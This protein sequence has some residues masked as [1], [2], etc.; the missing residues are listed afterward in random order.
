VIAEP[1]VEVPSGIL[2]ASIASRGGKYSEL[3]ANYMSHRRRLG[4]YVGGIR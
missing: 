2:G 3:L 4:C 1:R